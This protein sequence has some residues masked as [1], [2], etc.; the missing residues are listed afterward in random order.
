MKAAMARTIRSL[1][2][3]VL[4][5]CVSISIEK[6]HSVSGWHPRPLRD[7]G[8]EKPISPLKDTP[9]NDSGPREAPISLLN[10]SS[11]QAHEGIHSADTLAG[12]PTLMGKWD[13]AT[14]AHATESD[15]GL[16][17]MSSLEQ[18]SENAPGNTGLSGVQPRN[19][20]PT[21]QIQDVSAA[22]EAYHDA[23]RGRQLSPRLSELTTGDKERASQR[24]QAFIDN[25]CEDVDEVDECRNKGINVFDG[26]S[27][28]CVD[29]VNA[30]YNQVHD[31]TY[32]RYSNWHFKKTGSF[33]LL[34]WDDTEELCCVQTNGC[35]QLGKPERLLCAY[36]PAG[37]TVGEYPFSLDQWKSIIE[38]DGL[39]QTTI[40]VGGTSS[41]TPSVTTTST[42]TA[43]TT[44]TQTTATTTR[45]TTST[46]TSTHTTTKTTT[47]TTTST[48]TTT[49]VPPAPEDFT[50]ECLQAHNEK[51]VEGM[52]TPI[53][54]LV[55]NTG[56]VSQAEAYR[57]TIERGGCLFQH[58]GV[59]QVGP[60]GLLSF[61]SNEKT[62]TNTL[63]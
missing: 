63:I 1:A 21:I 40:I 15:I 58:S 57:D 42:R 37:N 26:T 56:A 31:Y 10:S 34:M 41:E 9:L 45:T 38:R 13:A 3:L 53:R 8:W 39:P 29:A 5:L 54:Q 4:S 16:S 59:R 30:W 28:S 50:D 46:S 17:G 23:K 7:L 25:G 47:T 12:S 51:R 43:T 32:E 11:V 24:L 36:S 27:V 19:V 14:P 2:G 48:T 60:W 18:L 20:T 55:R 62:D 6:Q 44:S 22:C 61:E 49:T 52:S 33:T 35:R